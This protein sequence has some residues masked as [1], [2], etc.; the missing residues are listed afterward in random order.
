MNRDTT[1]GQQASVLA[2][3]NVKGDEEPYDDEEE[4]MHEDE[5]DEMRMNGDDEIDYDNEEEEDNDDEMMMPGGAEAAGYNDLNG[6]G[7]DADDDDDRADL[8]DDADGDDEDFFNERQGGERFHCNFCS[9]TAKSQAKLKLH[10]STH[11][12]L[13]RYMCPICKKRANFKWDIQKHMRKM[14]NNFTDQVVCLSEIEARKSINTYIENSH[15]PMQNGD[16]QSDHSSTGGETAAHVMSSQYRFGA[17]MSERKY[18]CSLCMRTSKWQWDI[19]KH[20]RTVHKGQHGDVL[21]LE[22]KSHGGSRD[23]SASGIAGNGNSSVGSGLIR[24]P[25]SNGSGSSSVN[26]ASSSA[27]SIVSQ[28]PLSHSHFASSPSGNQF[29]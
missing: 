24:P 5:N 9:F 26:Y 29:G 4:N 7:D 14:H 13:K 1:R 12:N 3:G 22:G 2:N 15:M 8:A 18:K 16:A 23:I 10:L 27:S 25:P 19:K 6:G 20:M 11:Y 28:Q 21:V 17:L